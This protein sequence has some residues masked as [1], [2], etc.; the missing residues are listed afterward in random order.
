M[1]FPLMLQFMQVVVTGVLGWYLKDDLFALALLFG[2]L[3]AVVNSGMLVV[4]WRQGLKD[5]HCD[6]RRHL[7]S[8]NRSMLERFFVVGMLLAA[9]F[10]FLNL[11]QLVMLAGFIVG[12]TAWVISLTLSRRLS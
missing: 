11:P 4:R 12:Q 7:K 6:G 2:G 5:Y 1:F 10:K 3:V 9:G 8:F